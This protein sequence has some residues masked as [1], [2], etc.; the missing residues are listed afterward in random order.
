VVLA[1]AQREQLKGLL[2][3]RTAP[4]GEVL[5]ARVLLYREQGMDPNKIA[6]K[7][8][9]GRATVFNTLK[10]YHKDGVESA[11]KE[12]ARSGRPATY[13]DDIRAIIV[14]T[15]CISPKSLG[16]AQELWTIQT[17]TNHINSD[18]FQMS[19]SGIGKVSKSSVERV[20]QEA[21]IKPFRIKYYC[22]KRDPEFEQKMKDVLIVYKQVQLQLDGNGKI[23][24][25]ETEKVVTLSYDEKPGIQAIAATAPDLMPRAENG[26]IM[27]D[28]E[29]K[30]LG[31][32]SLL[33][34]IDLLSG[35]AT[36]HVSET[37]TSEDFVTFLKKLDEEYPKDQT[38][39]LILDNHSIHKSKRTIEYLQEREGRFKFVFTPKHGSWLNLI[40]S[41]F[42]KMTRQMLR[43]IRVATK[44]ELIERIYKYF[45]E[46]N[47]SPVVF[48]WK[49]KL[50]EVLV[51]D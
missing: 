25:S 34:G 39:R 11:L 4:A 16:Y 32:I 40:E 24:G 5:R 26:C 7:L 42:G 46:I 6:E 2:A 8:D 29:Y 48:R 49:Y 43:G 21:K 17:L 35:K 36:A 41:F 37:H 1:D 30:R 44:A 50:D 31:T 23:M 14:N 13:T 15:A 12:E 19:Q 20:L 28:A 51:A 33:A 38:L 27:R 45:N 18:G 22:E 10:K 47:E 3:K 9:V